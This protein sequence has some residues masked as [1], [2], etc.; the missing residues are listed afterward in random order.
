MLKKERI[1]VYPKQKF[2]KLILKKKPSPKKK[3]TLLIIPKILIL[4][5]AISTELN[6]TGNSSINNIKENEIFLGCNSCIRNDFL[7]QEYY[8]LFWN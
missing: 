2:S 6:E 3:K 1:L 7:F 8:M 4:L 5:I